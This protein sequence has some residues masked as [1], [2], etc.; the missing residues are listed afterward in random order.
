MVSGHKRGWSEQGFTLLEMVM[1]IGIVA[2]VSAIAVPNYQKI[3]AQHAYNQ[4]A[5]QLRDHLELARSY[6]QSQ[7]TPVKICPMSQEHLGSSSPTCLIKGNTQN[8]PAWMVVRVDNGQVLARGQK[9][10]AD[11]V[12]SSGQRDAFVFDERGT[13]SGFSNGSIYIFDMNGQQMYQLIIASNGRVT[14]L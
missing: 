9:P 7:Q 1:V 3:R 12:I 8:W 2:I 5:D 4:T 6:A 13:A 10:S 14:K 11:V